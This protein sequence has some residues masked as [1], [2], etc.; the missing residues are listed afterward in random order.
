MIDKMNISY[1]KGNKE[2]RPKPSGPKSGPI[3]T[4]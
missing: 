4:R 1:P 3:V 2:E